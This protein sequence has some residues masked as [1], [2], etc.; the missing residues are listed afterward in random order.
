LGPVRSLLETG[1]IKF[2]LLRGFG[3]IMPYLVNLLKL[4]VVLLPSGKE[5]VQSKLG[6]I[7]FR[8]LTCSSS[9]LYSSRA[10]ADTGAR[11]VIFVARIC[12]LC[13]SLS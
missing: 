9:G 5:G 4:V 2:F 8:G 10:K 6:L 12:L 13:N 11:G 3:W 1:E 7:P